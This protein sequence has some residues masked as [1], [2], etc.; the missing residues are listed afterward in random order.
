MDI[1][2]IVDDISNFK[3]LNEAAVGVDVVIHTAAVVDYMGEVD[4]NLVRKV[5]VK[6]EY[7]CFAPK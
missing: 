6:G 5:N 3:A 1:D 7:E 2:W 4:D